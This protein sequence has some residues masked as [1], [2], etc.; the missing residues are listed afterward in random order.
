MSEPETLTFHA[1]PRTIYCTQCGQAMLVAPQYMQASVA[2]PHC[3]KV[4]EPWRVV[5]DGAD[6]SG[7]SP[8]GTYPPSQAWSM[9]HGFPMGPIAGYSRRNRWIAGALG[10]LLGTFGVHR[11]YLGYTGIGLTQALLTVCSLGILSPFVA[12]WAFIEGILCFCGAMRDVDNMPL[13]G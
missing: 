11:F 13:S 4:L 9:E 1:S 7:P 12:I 8:G 2:C 3:D 10:I 6:N 5:R